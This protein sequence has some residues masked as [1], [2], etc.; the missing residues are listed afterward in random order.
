MAY[1]NPNYYQQYTAP[2][3][4]YQPYQQT[5]PVQQAQQA[6][7]DRIWVANEAA[8]NAYMVVANGFVR[9]WDSSQPIFYEK[10][11][12]ASGRPYPMV[13]YEYAPRTAPAQTEKQIDL[14]GYVTR[15]EFESWKQSMMRQEDTKNE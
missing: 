4:S 9:L 12:D 3:Q 2:V 8:A 7:D 6:Q 15:E 1:Y 13:V 5:Q 11:A 10:R 14:S